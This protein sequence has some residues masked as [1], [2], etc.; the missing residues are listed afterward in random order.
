VIGLAPFACAHLSTFSGVPR[1]GAI[2][3]SVGL[4]TTAAW[5][6]RLCCPMLTGKMIASRIKTQQNE[7]TQRR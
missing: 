3:G 1:G 6:V 2:V 4:I 7:F 5:A